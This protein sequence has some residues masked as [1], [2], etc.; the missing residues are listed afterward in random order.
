MCKT[1]TVLLF[2]R[3]GD[4]TPT[5]IH[6]PEHGK[7]HKFVRNPGT[8]ASETEADFHIQYIMGVALGILSELGMFCT[9]DFSGD[10]QDRTDNILRPNISPL[11]H[12]G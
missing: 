5:D 4:R 2:V 12:S 3:Y 7:L 11:A 8:G 1:V 10:L 6:K 9:I